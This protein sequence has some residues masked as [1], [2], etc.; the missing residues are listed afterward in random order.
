MPVDGSYEEPS[1]STEVFHD[2]MIELGKKLENPYSVVNMKR[3]LQ[4]LKNQGMLKSATAMNIQIETTHLY[5]RFLPANEEE[6][7]LIHRDT[8][9]VFYDHP[10][11]YEIKPGGTFFHDPSLPDTAI[12]WQ[13]T[14]VPVG[15]DFPPVRHEI[16]A[17]LYLVNQG[18]GQQPK[19]AG[20]NL[21]YW[22]LL[23][24]K[25]LEIT[26][27]LS[28]NSGGVALKSSRWTPHGTITVWDDVLDQQIPVQGAKVR[29]R[30][31]FTT[32]TGITDHNGS[33]TA[34]GT[35]RR[36][37]NYSIVWERPEWKIQDRLLNLSI[38]GAGVWKQVYFNGPK[39][40]GTWNLAIGNSANIDNS[41]RYAHI[42]RALVRY[43]YLNRDGLRS[44]DVR[45]L[46][47]GKLRVGYSPQPKTSNAVPY[48]NMTGHPHVYIY[49]RSTSA[50]EPWLLTNQIFAVT[51]HELVHVAHYELIGRFSFS[52]LW[53]DPD[54]RIIPESWAEAVEWRLTNIEYNELGQASRLDNQAARDYIHIAGRFGAGRQLWGI[55][56]SRDY[57]PLFI[58]LFDNVNQRRVN[59]NNISLPND[60]VTG[61]T[62]GV[63]EYDVLRRSF[64]I[65]TLKERLKLHK[66]QGVTDAQIDELVG[67]FT[68]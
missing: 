67:F 2:G 3:A 42:H 7:N 38:G 43:F 14:V 60:N 52:E 49:G 58:D 50:G 24:D 20:L 13:Y 68:N 8:T 5:V 30:R 41:M 61:Y 47:G 16:L 29:A 40:R 6:K 21:A 57:T 39:Q 53:L 46:L 63:L 59:S 31:W 23:E 28:C 22:E 34:D 51:I 26:G 35:F 33:F 11:D 18:S 44:P 17:E 32:H 1:A 62:F 48:R 54:G 27:N 66:P 45:S 12:T 64:G 9:L 36:E 65:K 4:E 55:E 19:S 56:Y 10:L 37:A 15:Y 25:A